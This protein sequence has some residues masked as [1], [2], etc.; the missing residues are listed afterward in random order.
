MI[1]SLLFI[2]SLNSSLQ[3]SRKI[4]LF[5]SLREGLFCPFDIPRDIKNNYKHNGNK[6]NWISKNFFFIFHLQKLS[7]PV[8]DV[9]WIISTVK[10]NF[11]FKCPKVIIKYM[12]FTLHIILLVDFS[13]IAVLVYCKLLRYIKRLKNYKN[14]FK[15]RW[16]AKF[17]SLENR[18]YMA[19]YGLE[20]S[21]QECNDNN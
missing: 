8:P 12:P 5:T 2:Q 6:N 20:N 18:V 14:T 10:A 17:R 19:V 4:A 11:R 9:Q 7:I 13:Y 1:I 3:N 15:L 16:H 21:Y